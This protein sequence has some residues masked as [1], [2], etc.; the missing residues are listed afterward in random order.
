MKRRIISLILLVC[1]M[2]PMVIGCGDKE[3]TGADSN[4]LTV[5]LPMSADVTDYENNV[6]TKYVEEKLGIQ[7]KFQ[8]FSS[9]GSSYIQQISLTASAGEKL[10]DVFWGL[11]EMP[12]RTANS[13][14][15]A[16]YFLDLTDLIEKYGV[17][18]KEQFNK[19]T[20][21]EQERVQR[22]GTSESGKFY[23]LPLM[24]SGAPL[25]DNLQ[26][27]IYIN[28]TWLDK[29]GLSMPTTI[30]EFVAVLRAFATQ[31]PNGNGQADEIP[32]LGQRSQKSN[33]CTYVINAYTYFDMNNPFNV[34]NG[35][36]TAPFITDEYR[37]AIIK[38]NEMCREGL[39]SDLTFSLASA[40]EYRQ[41][42]TPTNNVARVGV[43]N[44]HYL[45]Y[46]NV[47]SPV[48]SEYE[49][50]PRL[51]DATGKG[52]YDVVRANDLLWCGYITKDCKNPEL[53]MKFLDFFY[54]DEVITMIRH[55]EKGV[56]WD[57]L[58]EPVERNG[59]VYYLKAL[60]DD[61]TQTQNNTNNGWGRNGLGI[62]TYANYILLP[63][64]TALTN[65]IETTMQTNVLNALRV[66][67]EV[68]ND[69]HYTAEAYDE[70]AQYQTAVADYV[71][72]SLSLFVTGQQDP[73]DDAQWNAYVKE[74][75]KIGLNELLK[76]AQDAY[77]AKIAG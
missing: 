14:G 37:Q 42:N 17:H 71:N 62:M 77:D 59:A 15:D 64:E 46:T 40:A 25:Q 5:G 1:M 9:I 21:Q 27:M 31:D 57:Y 10:P 66:P 13:L 47:A 72:R 50:L 49:A 33:I 16:G 44:G 2:M 45:N 6:L 58:D 68:A 23:S 61:T 48:I 12:I 4:T 53:A 8:L 35:K 28:R 36:L 39:L 56:T 55:G 26:N 11:Q 19:L 18:Y 74:F 52:G 41:F 20:P 70:K 30:D 51:A 69:L 75:D 65:Q 73:K 54:Q 67:D 38:L 22:K 43:F 60:I 29:L 63:T 32:M 76:L 7:L 3:E 34:E 24:W